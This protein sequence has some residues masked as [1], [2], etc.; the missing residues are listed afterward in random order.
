MKNLNQAVIDELFLTG[1]GEELVQ[2]TL[3]QLS[4]IP[5]MVQIFGPY[6]KDTAGK[7]NSDQQRWA[8]Y[9][10]FDWSIRP[11][12]AI[13]IFE[14]QTE[15]KSA[16]NGF[17]I[18]NV[19]FQIFWPP[20]FRRSDLTGVAKAFKGALENFFASQLCADMLDELYHI[21]RPAKVAGLN[22]YGKTLSWSP[23][24]EGI[25]E[26]ELVPVT[27]LE[28]QYRIDLRAWYRTLEY[29]GRT[30]SNPFAKTL[31]D[32]TQIAGLLADGKGYQGIDDENFV[33]ITL[34]DRID[35]TNP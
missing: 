8:D 24:V 19:S 27:I 21:Q 9:Q 29:Q 11:L 4:S 2:K 32:L 35:V 33:W 34:E 26:S 31:D 14:S 5:G 22:E 17:L 1:P 30:K 16:E 7:K 6:K 10:R 3:L 13:N 18:G 25:V 12:P 20:N 28:V 23:N 15:A